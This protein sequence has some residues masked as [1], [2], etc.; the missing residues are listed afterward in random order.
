MI[1]PCE[2]IGSGEGCGESALPG[3]SYCAHHLAMVYQ[4]GTAVRRRRDR[5][6]AERVRELESLVNDAVAELVNEGMDL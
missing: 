3:R 5:R 6:R 2:W 1:E 4:A